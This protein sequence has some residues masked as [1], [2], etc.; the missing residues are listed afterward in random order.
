[1]DTAPKNLNKDVNGV[2]LAGTD[3]GTTTPQN[4]GGE[5][6]ANTNTDREQPEIPTDQNQPEGTEID[7]QELT[8]V[9]V[10]VREISG[11][12]NGAH[13]ANVM[14]MQDETY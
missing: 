8:P 2:E 11:L 9:R 1:M 6:I 3:G 13:I 14:Y 12:V 4:Q 5:T 10:F 7:S